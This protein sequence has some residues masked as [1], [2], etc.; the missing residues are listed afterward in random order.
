[1]LAVI[2][3][4]YRGPGNEVVGNSTCGGADAMGTSHMSLVNT[5]E[6]SSW[7]H[8]D[9]GGKPLA[10]SRCKLVLYWQDSIAQ[11]NAVN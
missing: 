2:D 6:A 10:Y 4:S 7:Y 1:M 11:T 5:F 9:A 3:F 8:G